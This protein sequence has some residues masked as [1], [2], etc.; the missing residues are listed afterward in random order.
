MNLFVLALNPFESAQY[1]CDKHVVKM[2]LETAQ[3]L[4]TAHWLCD[5]EIGE[6]WYQ[7]THTRHPVVRW[8]AEC[9][10]NY[11]YAYNMFMALSGEYEYR[12]GREHLSWQKLGE[13]LVETPD[14]ID[15]RSDVQDFALAMPPGA[16]GR[17]DPDS[18][19]SAYRRYYLS[20][21]YRLF[22]WTKRAVPWWVQN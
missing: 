16:L 5:G 2:V 18:A 19:V 13:V 10:G 9:A 1:H 6:G 7:P 14:Y 4:C 12:Y 11:R 17:V 22:K 20:H 8:C 15:E 21:K 3:I